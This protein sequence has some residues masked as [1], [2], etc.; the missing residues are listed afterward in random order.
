MGKSKKQQQQHP[1]DVL[2][3]AHW[4]GSAYSAAQFSAVASPPAIALSKKGFFG[5]GGGLSS[6]ANST[7]APSTYVEMPLQ[8]IDH[9]DLR[10][11]SLYIIKIRNVALSLFEGWDDD[12]CCFA[13]LR[14]DSTP[15]RWSEAR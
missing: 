8:S 7:K 9:D 2:S 4:S 5:G 13:I 12:M 3:L 1:E 15:M 6:S 10:Q 11:G 14:S